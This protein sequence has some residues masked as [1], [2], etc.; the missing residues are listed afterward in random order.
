M[1]GGCTR[2]VPLRIISFFAHTA[3]A[4]ARL[5]LTGIAGFAEQCDGAFLVLRY[6]FSALVHFSQS[7]A[8]TGLT[9]IARLHK[10]VRDGLRWP[11]SLYSLHSLRVKSTA[12]RLD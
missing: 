9:G 3:Q 11:V 4:E 7:E 2:L 12:C 6:T 8:P 1:P 5:G 10:Q